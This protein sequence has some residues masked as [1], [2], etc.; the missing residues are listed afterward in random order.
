MCV[1]TASLSWFNIGAR[2]LVPCVRTW[3]WPG[4]CTLSVAG[5]CCT[6]RLHSWCIHGSWQCMY[7]FRGRSCTWHCIHGSWCM[8]HAVYV[9]V[10]RVSTDCTQT[11]MCASIEWKDH[12]LRRNLH[13]AVE[14]LRKDQG[15]SIRKLSRST[16]NDSCCKNLST[17]SRTFLGGVGAFGGAGSGNVL[18][19]P[20]AVG[21]GCVVELLLQDSVCHLR[22]ATVQHG[23]ITVATWTHVSMVQCRA[24]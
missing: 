16:C 15:C 22:W 1:H 8:V 9:Y 23:I 14:F 13:D 10:M 20:A 11:N 12:G 7:M 19:V 4:A 6:W 5:R 24:V 3:P 21:C 2:G 17:N 18:C